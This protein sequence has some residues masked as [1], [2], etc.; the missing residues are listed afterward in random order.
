M[1]VL[2]P[3]PERPVTIT[4]WRLFSFTGGPSRL[5]GRVLPRRGGCGAAA[6]WR[7]GGG[8]AD[9]IARTDR[10]HLD[11]VV[12]DEPVPARDQIE[13]RLALADAAL[14][15]QQHAE[16]MYLD[17]D[18]VQQHVRREAVFEPRGDAADQLRALER[19]R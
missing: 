6:P 8:A 18:A 16:A 11:A 10:A 7:R 13:R 1:A 5:R 2:F 4:T 14:A 3:D 15:V 19:R 9:D 17:E 12:G